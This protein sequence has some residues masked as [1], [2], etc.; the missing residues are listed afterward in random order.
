MLLSSEDC[1]FITIKMR[2]K[3]FEY[4]T[5]MHKGDDAFG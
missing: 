1:W 4:E 5:R 2:M 3:K